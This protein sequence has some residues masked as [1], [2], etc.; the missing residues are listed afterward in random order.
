MQDYSS[1][2]ANYRVNNV[3]SD[4]KN[5]N[6]TQAHHE[7]NKA[8]K[9]KTIYCKNVERV[10]TKKQQLDRD[11]KNHKNEGDEQYW[12]PLSNLTTPSVTYPVM[13]NVKQQLEKT[14]R[15]IGPIHQI[16]SYLKDNPLGG[17]LSLASNRLMAARI[18]YSMSEYE[19][20]KDED[21]F[22]KVNQLLD[23]NSDSYNSSLATKFIRY[24]SSL[25][26]IQARVIEWGL[27]PSHEDFEHQFLAAHATRQ[28]IFNAETI[29]KFYEMQFRPLQRKIPEPFLTRSE[30]GDLKK[31]YAQF[32]VYLKDSASD[33][34]ASIVKQITA[35][36]GISSLD[37]E[38]GYRPLFS[39]RIGIYK[40][41]PREPVNWRTLVGGK[42]IYFLRGDSGKIYAA[43]SW[44]PLFIAA[45]VSALVS[46]H[47]IASIQRL[48][49]DET[50][51]GS[52][53]NIQA[54][55]NLLWLGTENSI[56][57]NQWVIKKYNQNINIDSKVSTLNDAFIRLQHDA[58]IATV[59]AFREDNLNKTI[60]EKILSF[61]PFFDVI[62][63]SVNDPHY[64]PTF[65][66]LL[67]DLID[68]GLTLIMLGIPLYK[69]GSAGIKV[70]LSALR[71]ARL[72]GL[73]GS[74]LRRA[75]FNAIKPT[76]LKMTTLTAKEV[77]C[78]IIPPLDLTRMLAR[79]LRR[80][81]NKLKNLQRKVI[82]KKPR[83]NK[84]M[85]QKRCRRAIGG[86]C[87][88]FTL[89]FDKE[90]DASKWEEFITQIILNPIKWKGTK[91]S[92]LYRLDYLRIFSL[93]PNK[94]KEALR[95]WT[96]VENQ[97]PYRDSSLLNWAQGKSNNN[98][99]LNQALFSG[100][101]SN[102]MQ[103]IADDL[104]EALEALPKM[105]NTQ[106]L[107]R[108]VDA[109]EAAMSKFSP[110][111]IVSN[112]PAFM[113]ASRSGKL[114]NIALN[115]GFMFI[116]KW[117]DKPGAAIV[118]FK[119]NG[120]SGKPFVNGVSTQ[121]GMEGEYLFNRKSFFQIDA[122][123]PVTFRNPT[124]IAKPIFFIKITEVS[125]DDSL[126]IKNIFT[127]EQL[128][129]KQSEF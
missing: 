31:Y 101:P 45:D 91:P 40:F 16:I 60:A 65:S 69:L 120:K 74:L 98:F 9:A 54:L 110:G 51:S 86:A 117:R 41:F 5:Q 17:Y 128:N 14:R 26:Y 7:K 126:K 1:H 44:D 113:S 116:R 24:E 18:A 27:D 95:G 93:L 118:I 12:Q 121:F 125:Y 47:Q 82:L 22:F 71:T 115:Q 83:S 77:A 111:D 97:K 64:S 23:N 32:N 68:L 10:R 15:W 89:Y 90:F 34:A 13:L 78:F 119:I 63:H 94:Y 52:T 46:E 42:H 61:V 112:Y 30:M 109:S 87:D 70:A 84:L 104:S 37:L 8:V 108:V 92:V 76:L 127:G 75:I 100:K 35:M 6:Q 88:T 38:R 49:N 4:L 96:Y 19:L 80:P 103:R 29:L 129:I 62:Q 20:W 102:D 48:R 43:S 50:V 67:G 72:Q 99:K 25:Y 79:L 11:V 2:T 73:V 122:I 28:R 107:I 3:C 56:P 57:V 81:I 55:N 53:I 39:L 21:L 66:D 85:G 123:T 36:Q 33:D 124:R 106:Q 58:V 114:A 105:G 59:V